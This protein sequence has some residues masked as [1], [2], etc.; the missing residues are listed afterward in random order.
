MSTLSIKPKT[1]A[2]IEAINV[3]R[4]R[5]PKPMRWSL[6]MHSHIDSEQARLAQ[7][8]A[9]RTQ[10]GPRLSLLDGGKS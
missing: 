2:D 7:E 8:D 4:C 3:A 10:G 1:M 6:G 5:E 9:H